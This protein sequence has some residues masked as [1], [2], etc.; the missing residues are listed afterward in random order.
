MKEGRLVEAQRSGT[1]V[2]LS[3]G[4]RQ[5]PGTAPS[6]IQKEASPP[7]FAVM[8]SPLG[9]L[10][11]GEGRAYSSPGPSFKPIS[12]FICMILRDLPPTSPSEKRPYLFFSCRQNPE[13]TFEVYVEV[14]CPFA[15]GTGKVPGPNHF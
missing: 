7:A 10:P 12:L 4:E 5:S 14:T 11:F 15:S 9:Q 3:G 1:G 2:D 13:T 8:L 6:L